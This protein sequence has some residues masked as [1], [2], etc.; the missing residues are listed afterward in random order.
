MTR[1]AVLVVSSVVI[2][3]CVVWAVVVQHLVPDACTYSPP[4]ANAQYLDCG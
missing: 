1:A 2:V 3:A 4:P